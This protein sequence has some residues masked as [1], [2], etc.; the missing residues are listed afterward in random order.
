MSSPNSVSSPPSMLSQS[1]IDPSTNPL[2]TSTLASKL[3]IPAAA[4]A[5]YASLFKQPK[6]DPISSPSP[7]Q[8][9]A[10][11]SASNSSLIHQHSSPLDLMNSS[12]SSPANG[13]QLS[14]NR[15]LA[16]S[17]STVYEFLSRISLYL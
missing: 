10:A 2:I 1:M 3:P 6:L 16:A 8:F 13:L 14:L 17:S 5:A 9:A 7:V 11:D 4:A 15:Q 12:T